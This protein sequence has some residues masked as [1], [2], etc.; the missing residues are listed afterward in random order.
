[1]GILWNLAFDLILL[2]PVLPLPKVGILGLSLAATTKTPP[3]TVSA[4][5]FFIDSKSDLLYSINII[6]Y[7]NMALLCIYS[8][9]GKGKA[10]PVLN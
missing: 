7:Y 10:V 5:I 4:V 2:L 1:M 3:T 9:H 8:I 6:L